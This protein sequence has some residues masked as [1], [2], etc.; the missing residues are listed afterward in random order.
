MTERAREKEWL[1]R[2]KMKLRIPLEGWSVEFLRS[3]EGEEEDDSTG[4]S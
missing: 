1:I 2:E 3:F 4:M